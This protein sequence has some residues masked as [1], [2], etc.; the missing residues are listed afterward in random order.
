MK[1]V[2]ANVILRYL[3]NDVHEM[4]EKATQLLENN[5]VYIPN[6]ITAEVVYVLEKIYKVGRED[7][8]NIKSA[9]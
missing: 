4:A 9:F 6:E 7:I 3:L 5:E 8:S 1:I 2:D